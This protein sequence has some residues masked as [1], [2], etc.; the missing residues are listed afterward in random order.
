MYKKVIDK[1]KIEELY[2]RLI[3]ISEYLNRLGANPR[4]EVADNYMKIVNQ[5]SKFLNEDLEDFKLPQ[6]AL[7]ASLAGT[8]WYCAI[9]LLQPKITE[10]IHFLKVRYPF[11]N[12]ESLPLD[13][14]AYMFI[15]KIPGFVVELLLKRFKRY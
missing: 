5:L 8:D 11:L 2:S 13:V 4:K 7:F 9:D 14:R 1:G 15:R 10:L 6:N 3:G 12:K